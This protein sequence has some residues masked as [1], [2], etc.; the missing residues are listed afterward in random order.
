MVYMGLRRSR[1]WHSMAIERDSHI[2]GVANAT[3][4]DRLRIVT[5]GEG[6]LLLDHAVSALMT[7]GFGRPWLSSLTLS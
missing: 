6:L 7:E 5:D 2:D 1:F 4:I 3:T